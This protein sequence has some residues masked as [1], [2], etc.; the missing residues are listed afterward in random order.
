MSEETADYD[1]IA[2]AQEPNDTTTSKQ[3]QRRKKGRDPNRKRH[4]ARNQNRHKILVKWLID[5][6]DLESSY[7]PK[8]TEKEEEQQQRSHILD[9][10]GGRGEVSARLTM[11]HR[12][13]VVM[14]DPR[15]ANVVDCF[16]RLVL[17]KIPNKWQQKLENQR[18]HNPNFVSNVIGS[19]FQQLATTFDTDTISTNED[20]QFAIQNSSLILGLHAD[21]ATEAI[22]DAA[23]QYSKP[24]VV[25]PCCVFPNLFQSRTIKD[26]NGQL[27][28]VRSHEQF[29]YYLQQKD[30]RRFI[31]EELPFEG[32]NIAIWWNGK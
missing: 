14:V 11:C 32:R 5:T 29:C 26:S 20:L 3:H 22:V 21:G 8:E 28:Q 23:I 13:N 15:P 17:P 30:P 31:M 6:F 1:A 10:A 9:V 12:Q 19:R 27:V 16:E 18:L 4:G 24:F 2:S 7:I 25:I